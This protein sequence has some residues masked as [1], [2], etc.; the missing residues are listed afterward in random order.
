MN[1]LNITNELQLVEQEIL[2]IFHEVCE[3]YRL[4]YS[5]S[6]GTLLGAIRHQGYIPWDDDI[7]IMMPRADYEKL[8]RIWPKAVRTGYI[9]QNYREE[10]DLPN[11][12]AKI[13]K[14][15]TTFIQEER[16]KN[17]TYH[18]G[19]F[20]DI[21]PFDR[22]PRGTVQRKIQK[23]FCMINLLYSR[24]YSSRT[25]GIT[26]V[27]EQI[28]LRVVP[29]KKYKT[30]SYFFE[31]LAASWN[32][33]GKGSF[34]GP[35]SIKGCSAYLPENVF[36]HYCKVS[37]NGRKYFAVRD[38]DAVLKVFY[39]DYMELPPEK[40]RISRHH[41]LCVDFSRNYEEL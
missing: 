37:F 33:I 24:G 7:D 20:I 29:Y 13:R 3:K 39:G 17:C 31:R 18:K 23:L 27:V 11:N 34:F 8:L 25:G 40:D 1:N 19:I 41:P 12:F 21:F 9:L 4:R 22:V 10:P 14:D 16:E 30:V 15:H 35:C 38:Y 6:Y 26:E 36:D 5:L 2:D 32:R 28:L